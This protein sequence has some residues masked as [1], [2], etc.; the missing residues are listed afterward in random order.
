MTDHSPEC[1][2][3]DPCDTHHPAKGVEVIHEQECFITA[4]TVARYC[5]VCE[6]IRSTSRRVRQETADRATIHL[7]LHGWH[8]DDPAWVQR[9]R[10]AL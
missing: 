6:A 3:T 7:A 5:R 1:V 9:F 8:P 4:N 2:L 10:A